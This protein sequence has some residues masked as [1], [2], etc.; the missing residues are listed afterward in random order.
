MTASGDRLDYPSDPSSPTVSMLD[1]KTHMNSTTSD[2]SD[3]AR[4]LCLEI[5]NCHLGTPMTHFQC[6]RVLPCWVTPQEVWDDPT[7]CNIRIAADDNI[8]AGHIPSLHRKSLI[9]FIPQLI[10]F[11]ITINLTLEFIPSS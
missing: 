7:S 4:H 11:G 10:D 5:K 8:R 2:A 1:A 6:I 9:D 3:G